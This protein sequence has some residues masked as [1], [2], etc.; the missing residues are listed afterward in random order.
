MSDIFL[1][2][3]LDFLVVD[4]ESPGDDTCDDVMFS[5]GLGDET[6]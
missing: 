2:M 6:T 4:G 5:S 1:L 3:A